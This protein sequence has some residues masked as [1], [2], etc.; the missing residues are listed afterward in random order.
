[1]IVKLIKSNQITPIFLIQLMKVIIDT[2][3]S[4]SLI[5]H[6]TIISTNVLLNGPINWN[7]N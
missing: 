6:H 4:K 1:M 3:N 5:Q 7:M 2:Y